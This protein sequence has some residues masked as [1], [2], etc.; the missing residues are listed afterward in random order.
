M[1]FSDKMDQI[2]MPQ[3]SVTCLYGIIDLPGLCQ[4]QVDA[5]K[6]SAETNRYL[7]YLTVRKL[8]PILAKKL[9]KKCT[10]IWLLAIDIYIF[11]LYNM[12]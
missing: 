9:L 11:Y 3:A 7:L 10:Y 2:E 6:L 12:Q 4:R 5:V 8:G 1:C